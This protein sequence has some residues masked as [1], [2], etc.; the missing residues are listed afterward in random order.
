MITLGKKYKDPITSF[1]GIAISRTIH[2]SGCIH[3]GLQGK[4]GK[5]GKL[6]Q[7]EFFDESRLD[8]KA[9]EQG[10]PAN[11]RPPRI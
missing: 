5:D 10:G 4:C 11:F 9:K 7:A 2:L 6:P 8:P 1:E 3:I